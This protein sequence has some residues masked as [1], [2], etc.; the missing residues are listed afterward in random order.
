MGQDLLSRRD[1][2]RT[3]RLPPDQTVPRRSRTYR[4]HSIRWD[5]DLDVGVSIPPEAEG[6]IDDFPP[7]VHDVLVDEVEEN[8]DRDRREAETGDET[9]PIIGMMTLSRG[10]GETVDVAVEWQSP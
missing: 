2:T 7:V 3:V 1:T 8:V 4:V 9:W 10:E 6:T 5:G